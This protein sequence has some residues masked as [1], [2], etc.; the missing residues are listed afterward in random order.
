VSQPEVEGRV[1]PRVHYRF[2]NEFSPANRHGRVEL[3]VTVDGGA[4]LDHYEVGRVRRWTARLDPVVWP[5]LLDELR[6]SSFPAVEVPPIPPGGTSHQIEVVG[7]ELAGELVLDRAAAPGAGLAGALRILD[8][9][10]HQLSGGAVRATRDDL[11]Q[12]AHWI[13]AEPPEAG[14]AVGVASFGMAG[15]APAYAVTTPENSFRLFSVP[16]GEP[17]GASTRSSAPIRALALGAAG[18]RELLATG[19][20]DQIVKVWDVNTGAEL[21]AR[22]GP[23][24]AV[25]AVT[26]PVVGGDG[27][28]F[29]AGGDGRVWSWRMAGGVIEERGAISGWTGSL[30]D[31]C[32]ARV[33]DLD[34]VA[35]GGDE[36]VVY[37]WNV[38][39]GS[40]LHTLSGHQGWAN[41]VSM[42]GTGRKGLLASGGADGVVRVWDLATGKQVHAL[43]GQAAGASGVGQTAG[44]TG[45]VF[46]EVAGQPVV[47]SCALDG[48]LRL[49][50]VASGDALGAWP[51]GGDWPSGIAAIQ[52][53]DRSV[54]VTSCADGPVRGWDVAD[55]SLVLE[56]TADA[57][58]GAV[59]AL[60]AGR[61]GD[62][63]L[64]ATGYPDGGMRL[65][66]AASGSPVRT[67]RPADGRVTSV[68]FGLFGG[69]P[70]LV[71]GDA[72]G[73]V[74]VD[75][76][77][78]G[79]V[80]SV[81]TPHT[82]S[83]L[84]LGFA[85]VGDRDVVVSGGADGTVRVW[86]ALTGAPLRRMLGHLAAVTAVTAGRVG[87]RMVIVS[88]GRDR[89]VRSWDA[90]TGEPLHGGH[91]HPA[92]VY[93]LAFGSLEHRPVIASGGQDGTVRIWD[94]ATGAELH[95]L[96]GNDGTVTALAFGATDGTSFLAVATDDGAVRVWRLPDGLLAR[97]TRLAQR[98]MAA[99]F[100]APDRFYVA[101]RSGLAVVDI[102]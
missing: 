81:P 47:A 55:G 24:G 27:W 73:A 102:G 11:P 19:G 23:E 50:D 34:L 1:A 41:A 78:S 22:G 87:D 42:M 60:A 9:L 44:V 46:G 99:L 100:S 33:A 91:G 14:A 21:H 59:T 32:F 89:V 48:M 51:C 3:T 56:L 93:C 49:W 72:T 75:D 94:A 101:G 7:A 45:V 67:H 20:D 70:V 58:G 39:D 28:I 92:P 79:E 74:R 77:G 61:S 40:N 71:T 84:A 97:E 43:A 25:R 68:A 15:G 62:R 53:G 63:T 80:L 6:R 12:L 10:V 69:A 8:S 17:R 18:A 85:T 2:G 5:R 82:G 4:R 36:G 37:V 66:D 26:A 76:V 96:P 65:W 30:N 13:V 54:I 57:L 86:D 38:A 88:A 35:A 83:V 95:V 52:T 90:A 31:V 16:D 64:L 29:A 98:P